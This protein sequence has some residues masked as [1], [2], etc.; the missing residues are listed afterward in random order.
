VWGQPLPP[1]ATARS[2]SAGARD[3]PRPPR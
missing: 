2:D 3:R 1:R